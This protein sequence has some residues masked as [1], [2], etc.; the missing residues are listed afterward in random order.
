MPITALPTPPSRNDPLNF[1]TRADAFLGALPTFALELNDLQLD[2]T[3]SEAAAVAA[4]NTANAAATAATLAAG[5][6]A[7]VSG[8]T[9]SI[10]QQVWSPTTFQTFRRRTA[11]AGTT[12]PSSDATNWEPLTISSTSG[13]TL[14]NNISYKSR[15][16]AGTVSDLMLITPGNITQLYGQSGMSL[17][18]NGSALMNLNISGNVGIGTATPGAA[19]DVLKTTNSSLKISTASNTSEAILSFDVGNLGLTNRDSQ[20]RGT[21]NGS[22]QTGLVFYTSNAT[23][24]VARMYI[25][26]LGNV[27]IGIDAAASNVRLVVQQS[28]SGNTTDEVLML[29]NSAANGPFIRAGVSANTGSWNPLVVAGDQYLAF[30]TGASAGSSSNSLSI[31]PWSSTASGIRI[32]SSGFVG[33]GASPLSLLHLTSLLPEMIISESDQ[34]LDAKSWKFSVS[35]STFNFG[36]ITDTNSATSNAYTVTRTGN[37]VTS[38]E[39]STNGVVRLQ[40]ASDGTV[41]YGGI[42]IGYKNVPRVTGTLEQG[43]CFATPSGFTLSS[44]VSAGATY[45]VYNDSGSAITITQGAGLTLRLAGSTSTGNRTIAP[46]GMATIW[47]NSSTEAIMTGAGV[48]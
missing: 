8:T 38:Q 7:W 17:F 4:A 45:S 24:P 30:G 3:G 33:L 44:G 11:G 19:L 39:F 28:T 10:G 14:N 13:I 37:S 6:S 9:Y 12:D 27:G 42:E 26:N 2:V 48:S 20:I 22:N 46:R 1:P 34:G 47:Y 18:V 31:V 29:K 40:I 16:A 21:N 35:G 5:V 32:N 15:L 41:T 43:K 25:N 36:T 23:T